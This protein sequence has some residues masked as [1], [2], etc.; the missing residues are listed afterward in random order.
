MAKPTQ[1]Q[2]TIIDEHVAGLFQLLSNVA[3]AAIVRHEVNPITL[4]LNELAARGYDLDG[5]WIGFTA[6]AKLYHRDF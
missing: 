4:A 6:A 1:I 5:K 3:L 2:V